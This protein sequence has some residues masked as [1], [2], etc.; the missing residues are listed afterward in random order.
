MRRYFK[1]AAAIALAMSC[2]SAP[3]LAETL[4]ISSQTQ[5]V[6]EHDWDTH[7]FSLKYSDG[8]ILSSEELRGKM[9]FVMAW[10]SWCGPC[11]PSLPK[12][13][14]LYEGNIGNPYVKVLSAHLSSRYGRFNSPAEVLASK[15]LYYPIIEDPDGQ[16]VNTLGKTSASFG[17]PHYV[18][19]DGSGKII[20]RY[21]EI[22]D[23]VIMDVENEFYRHTKA[24]RAK[25][26]QNP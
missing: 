10:A 11:K 14:P 1:T 4:E 5:T 18:L 26:F 6:L 9:V 16:F 25:A 7:P 13:A 21:G 2:L 3:T 15:G 23:M 22:N 20:R 19:I 24:E 17:V 8:R 12:Y